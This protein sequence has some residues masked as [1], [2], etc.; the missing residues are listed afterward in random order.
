MEILIAT[1]NQNKALEIANKLSLYNKL[2]FK[3]LADFSK[4]EPPIEDGKTF[5]E[6]AFIKASFYAKAFKINA[7]ADDS[8]LCVD[9][10]GGRPGIHSARYAGD[11]ATDTDLYTK[12][13]LEL[14][15]IANRN[16]HF[17]CA[18]SLVSPKGNIIQR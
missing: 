16:A 4:I 12:L 6:N 8:G 13:L 11:N 14:K 10:L 9:A 15:G 1:S 7:L 18:M 17:H 2:Q 3:S 5:L